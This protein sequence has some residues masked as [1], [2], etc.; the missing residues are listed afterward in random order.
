MVLYAEHNMSF[1]EVGFVLILTGL[2]AVFLADGK[3]TS[4]DLRF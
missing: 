1:R 3:W 4:E 2:V